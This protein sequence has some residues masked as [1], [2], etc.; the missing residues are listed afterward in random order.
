MLGGDGPKT[1]S[2]PPSWEGKVAEAREI[3]RRKT[4]QKRKLNDRVEQGVDE[5]GH[6][7]DD[8][9]GSNGLEVR[10]VDDALIDEMV[11]ADMVDPE[12]MSDD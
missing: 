3:S 10:H 5:G 7:M 6:H 1:Y 8:A 4:I 2:S 11:G 12:A 9:E